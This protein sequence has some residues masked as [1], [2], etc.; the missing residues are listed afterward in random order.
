M[1][2]KAITVVWRR[3]GTRGIIIL[4]ITAFAL[5]LVLKSDFSTAIWGNNRESGLFVLVG[6]AGFGGVFFSLFWVGGFLV[7]VLVE[8]NRLRRV[9]ARS[10]ERF[11]ESVA[12]GRTLDAAVV[13]KAAH[14]L[15]DVESPNLSSPAVI[16]TDSPATLSLGYLPNGLGAAGAVV[17]MIVSISI[18]RG[19]EVITLTGK[20]A[21]FGFM[22]GYPVGATDAGRD[23]TWI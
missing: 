20:L 11:S 6:L 2:T 15:R 14:T 18:A 16:K 4:L 10:P 21:A 8:W 13:S 17:G 19:A 22:V 3:I 12:I 5:A 1:V 9:A 7:C 23:H